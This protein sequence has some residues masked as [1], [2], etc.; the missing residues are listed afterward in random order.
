M[1]L[2]MRSVPASCLIILCQ[3]VRVFSVCSVVCSARLHDRVEHRTD[4]L[5]RRSGFIPNKVTNGLCR[6]VK[7]LVGRRHLQQIGVYAVE[8]ETHLGIRIV[9][10]PL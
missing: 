7:P 1:Y 10:I 3:R 5:W 2:R 4:M 8:L 9:R 6:G